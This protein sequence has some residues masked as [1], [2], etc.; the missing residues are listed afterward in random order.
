MVRLCV[1]SLLFALWFL[2]FATV[3][4][5]ERETAR[6][7]G[8]SFSSTRESRL[9][10]AGELQA[11]LEKHLSSI[12]EPTPRERDWLDRQIARTNESPN[13]IYSLYENEL[14]LRSMLWITLDNAKIELSCIQRALDEPAEMACWAELSARW[15]D[16]GLD[17]YVSGLERKSGT[18]SDLRGLPGMYRL[19]GTHILKK[20]VVPYLNSLG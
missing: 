14:F 15:L 1:A 17:S 6:L 2:P 16:D 12:D 20:I 5:A 13:A 19:L 3:E 11:S 18:Y 4:A 8:Q 9:R 7:L 10:I